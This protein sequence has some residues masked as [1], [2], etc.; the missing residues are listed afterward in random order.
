MRLAEKMSRIGTESAY[1]V[2][3]KARELERQGKNVIHLE[4]GEPDFPTPA[5]VIEAGKRALDDGWTKYGPTPGF[6]EFR[7]AIAAYVSRTRGI[8]VGAENVC[9]VPGGKPIMFFSMLALLEPGDEVIYPNPGF[10]IYES[11][12]RFLGATPIP[13]PLVEAR[14]FS[15]DL[16]LFRD[17]LRDR[18][19]LVILNSPQNPTGGQIPAD[20]IAAMAEM[21]RDR[22]V[23]V[24]SDEIYSR[25]YYGEAPASIASYPGMLE[26]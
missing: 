21:L 14:D 18:T 5:H 23:M 20:D 2:L 25:I 15:F 8:K 22:D 11:M 7:E 13:I 17:R 19:K 16:D 10:P 24:L 3:A 4:I 6:P 1:E 26:K 9:V 12:I